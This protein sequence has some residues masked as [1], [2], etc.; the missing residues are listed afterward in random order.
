M[1]LIDQ[2]TINPIS[3]GGMKSRRG[4]EEGRILEKYMK[5]QTIK[6]SSVASMM[7]ILIFLSQKRP[8]MVILR[9]IYLKPLS[10]LV[11]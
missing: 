8:A 4:R 9:M 3:P 6:L 2:R 11:S 10:T 1:S 7:R 5:N